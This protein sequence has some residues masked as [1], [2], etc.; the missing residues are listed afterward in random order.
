MKAKA[1]WGAIFDWDGV[2]ID[3]SRQH[4]L[5]WERLAAEEHRTLPPDHFE[6]GFGMRNRQIVP[7]IL[8]WTT[9]PAEIARLDARK[10]EL[11]RELVKAEGLAPLPGVVPFLKRLKAAAVPAVIA[12]STPRINLDFLLGRL[13]LVRYFRHH[14]TSEDVSHGKPDPEVFLQAVAR[15]GLWPNR[16]VVFE[17]SPVG[18]Q[19]ARAAGIKVVA[20]TTSHPPAALAAA[21]RCV[22]R[23]DELTPAALAAWLDEP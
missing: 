1:S 16:C 18:L 23:L 12:T 13:H 17:D 10:E 14:V 5:S 11:F 22:A 4:R 20:V 6:R 2:I 21:D 9:D 19:A 3:S 7:D 15:L 8:G